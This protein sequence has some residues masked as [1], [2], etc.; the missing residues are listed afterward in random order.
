MEELTQKLELC[1]IGDKE[2]ESSSDNVSTIKKC[3]IGEKDEKDAITQIHQ[4]NANKQYTE[5]MNIFGEN[6]KDGV[7]LLNPKTRKPIEARLK[8]SSFKADIICIVKDDIF[9]ISIKSHSGANFSV[10]NHTARDAL[11]FQQGGILNKHLPNLDKL[12]KNYMEERTRQSKEDIKISSLEAFRDSGVRESIIAV[13]VFFTFHGTGSGLSQCPANSILTNN[14]GTLT[15]KVYATY[16]QQRE[17]VES[18]LDRYV[19]SLRRKKGML[20]TINDENKPWIFKDNDKIKG[21][22]HIRVKHTIS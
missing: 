6:A 7:I 20:N 8:R 2:R 16:K 5:L 4:Y 17:Y 22:F 13:L 3:N 14:K 9:Y 12:I 19:M 15:F 11:V 10:I 1:F 21:L 18:M